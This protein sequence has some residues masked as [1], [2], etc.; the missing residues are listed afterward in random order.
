MAESR[1][2]IVVLGGSYGGISTSHYVLKHVIPKLATPS[3][4]QLVLV[5][6]STHT[7]CRPA[8]P[9]ALISDD[10]FDQSKLFVPI[11]PQFTQYP[12]G[13]FR[14]IHGSAKSLN[15]LNRAVVVSS[16]GIAKS[17]TIEFHSLVVATGASTYSPLLGFSPNQGHDSLK[18][19]WSEFRKALA[20][21]KSIVIAGGGPAGI[22]IAGEL[23]EH[24]NGRAGWLSSTLDNPKVPIT[25]ICASVQIL[26]LLRP[27]LATKAEDMLAKVGVSILKSTKVV[28][29]SPASSSCDMTNLMTKTKIILNNGDEIEADIYIPATGTRPNTSFVAKDLLVEDGRIDTNKQTFRVENAGPRI[30][31][32]GDCSSVFRPAVHNILS[33]VPVLAMNMRKDL[34]DAEG[35][36]VTGEARLF[37]EDTRETQLVPIGK[38]KGVGAA[39]GWALPSWMVWL[40]KG[41]DY[42]IWVRTSH[43]A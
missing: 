18:Q 7:V 36:S 13:R 20:K 3:S 35:K 2:N 9:R 32:I 4:Y 25:V 14:F 33:A 10:F 23:G 8:C 19:T 40:I 31:S 11:E 39:M 28:S 29:A 17:E 38:S 43:S 26:P 16:T 42:W 21:A 5:S 37:K 27:G 12:K 22:E 1:K 30:Y 6:P 24:L 41:R 34:L 15:C